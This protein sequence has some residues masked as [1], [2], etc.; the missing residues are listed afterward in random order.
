MLSIAVHLQRDALPVPG[1]GVGDPERRPGECF[2]I[3]IMATFTLS[4]SWQGSPTALLKE[5]L[6]EDYGRRVS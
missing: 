5:P 2:P 6:L 1:A 4:D 3:L